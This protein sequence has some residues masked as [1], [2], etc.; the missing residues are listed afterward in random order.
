MA[1]ASGLGRSNSRADVIPAVADSVEGSRVKSRAADS[2]RSVL[3]AATTMAAGRKMY[4]ARMEPKPPDRREQNSSRIP[5]RRRLR[6]R[7]HKK[8]VNGKP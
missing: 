1:P 6:K 4:L 3:Q 2:E 5:K 8:T 7:A